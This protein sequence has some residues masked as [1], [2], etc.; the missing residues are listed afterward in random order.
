M[1][2]QLQNNRAF[3]KPVLHQS[4]ADFIGARDW[5][6]FITHTFTESVGREH[7]EKHLH[8]F[9]HLQNIRTYGRNYRKRQPQIEWIAG[10][11]H[12]K[13]GAIHFHSIAGNIPADYS[14][15]LG[16]NDWLKTGKRA[17]YIKIEPVRTPADVIFYTTKYVTKEGEIL[18]SPQLTLQRCDSDAC[19]PKVNP[20]DL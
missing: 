11:E 1:P 14:Y 7:S 2:H 10:L 17:G 4:W 5:Q 6:L 16:R 9:F 20:L 19:G 3:L 8:K 18:L 13:S 12:H 15:E